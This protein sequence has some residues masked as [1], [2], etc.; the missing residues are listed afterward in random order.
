MKRK[1]GFTLIEM[2]ASMA[3]LV[4]I[5]SVIA[6]LMLLAIKTNVRNEKDLDSNSVSK[7]F[8]ELLNE[9]K[10]NDLSKKRDDLE[11]IL[12]SC[13]HDP[14]NPDTTRISVYLFTFD[15]VSDLSG[16]V[17]EFIKNPSHVKFNNDDKDFHNISSNHD[18]TYGIKIMIEDIGYTFK[19]D[20][21]SWN[22]NKISTSKINRE[23]Y[24]NYVPKG[25]DS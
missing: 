22:L 21:N 7:A 11:N 8:V 6:S 18:E 3:M 19:I 25:S 2:I 20:I 10:S 24:I 14:S 12:Y 23:I 1:K 16:L 13:T 5:F 17:T 4:L 9:K 15:N